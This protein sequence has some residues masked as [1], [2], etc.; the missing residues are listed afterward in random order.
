MNDL[1][2]L[3]SKPLIECAYKGFICGLGFLADNAPGDTTPQL[4]VCAAG[5]TVKAGERSHEN[6]K[7]RPEQYRKPSQPG[8]RVHGRSGPSG[9]KKE[10]PLWMSRGMGVYK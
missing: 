8:R 1:S 10:K 6:C 2:H 4:F 5:F 3:W 9:R 7:K